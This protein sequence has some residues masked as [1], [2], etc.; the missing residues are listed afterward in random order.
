MTRV[1]IKRRV[2]AAVEGA[3][4]AGI[5]V[6]RIEVDKNGNVVI[7]AGKSTNGADVNALDAWMTKHD[8]AA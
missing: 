4:S 8:R 1:N 2:A 7:V 6:G 3:R 5:D